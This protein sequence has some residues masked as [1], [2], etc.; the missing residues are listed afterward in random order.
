M[1]KG[2]QRHKSNCQCSFC[3]TR[4][5]EQ[6]GK[7]NPMYG[8]KHKQSSKTLM[9]LHTKPLINHKKDCQCF[10]CKAIRGETKGKNNPFYGHT[11]TPEVIETTRQATIQRFK[12]PAERLKVSKHMT[13]N[14]KKNG[15][16]KGML[17]KKHKR[18]SK[19]QIISTK[20][21]R[22]GTLNFRTKETNNRMLN[23][24]MKRYGKLNF[25]TDNTYS[26]CKRGWKT[27]GDQKYFF[28]S[29]WEKNYACYLEWL[30]Q[31]GEIKD[32]KF[33]T[34]TFWF[35]NIKRGIRSYLPDFEVVTKNDLIEYHEVK[36]YMDSKSKTK[37]KRMTKYYPDIK[38]ILIDG[39]QYKSIKQISRLIPDW[40]D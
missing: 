21:E 8:R 14:I 24:R 39:E 37:L 17:N 34:K 30:K 27:V 15:H 18:K 29:G 12:D 6:I 19:D 11:Q 33:E 38:M 40:E 35:E 1:L 22:Y 20:L 2:S 23:T 3:K 25:F 9:R 7:N 28:R 16:P 31:Q 10:I 26:R 13:E 4:R 36:G 5:G 32:W